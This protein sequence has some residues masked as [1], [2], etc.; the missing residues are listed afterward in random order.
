MTVTSIPG[1]QDELQE[2]VEAGMTAVA[3]RMDEVVDHH[4]PF[5]AEASGHLARAGGKR[6]RPLLTL[7]ASEVGSG[8]DEKVVD[9]AVGVELTHLASLYHDD[10][11]DEA[12]LRRGVESANSRYGNST[13]I[14]IGDLL[15]GT[16]SSVV[17]GL[18]AEAVRIQADTFVRLCAGQIRDDRQTGVVADPHEAVAAYLSILADKT[19]SLIATAA[20]YGAMFGGCDPETVGTLTAYAEQL[21]IVFQLADDVLDVASDADDSGKTPGADLREGKAT[22]PVLYART[23]SDPADERLLT[24]TRGPIEDPDELAE[25][26]T[27]LRAHP[28]MQQARDHTLRVAAEARTLLDGLPE[29][30]AVDAL[31][32]LVDGVAARSS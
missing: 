13:A 16:A 7:L 21:G 2:R 8:W 12:D 27:L 23:S 30:P 22:L 29:G 11:M 6:F 19:G 25:A 9:A 24:L 18:G 15:F 32:A 20:R 4:D 14:L 10:V 31:R 28:A 5:I 3:A 1:V 17:A 26:L